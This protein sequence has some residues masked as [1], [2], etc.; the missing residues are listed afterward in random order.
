MS[1]Y[2]IEPNCSFFGICCELNEEIIRCMECGYRFVLK[3]DAP[4]KKPFCAWWRRYTR[5]DGFCH[6]G[7]RSV[8]I[9]MGISFGGIE[10]PQ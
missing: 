9:D 2:I 4:P 6:N 3:D 5:D 7:K 10:N 8:P 1:E